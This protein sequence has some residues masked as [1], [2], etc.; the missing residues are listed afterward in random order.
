MAHNGC[1]WA[2]ACDQRDG[3]LIKMAELFYEPGGPSPA[4][5]NKRVQFRPS[6]LR[7]SI[8]RCATPG[9][10]CPGQKTLFLRSGFPTLAV[11]FG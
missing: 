8:D 4:R 9:H 1:S 2:A 10:F 5:S 11:G 6:A 7:A 3:V